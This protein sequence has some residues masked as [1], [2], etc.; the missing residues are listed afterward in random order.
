MNGLKFRIIFLNQLN[1][2]KCEEMNFFS[3]NLPKFVWKQVFFVSFCNFPKSVLS[4][5]LRSP[6]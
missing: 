4:R 3:M 2:A 1:V 6:Y 5:S